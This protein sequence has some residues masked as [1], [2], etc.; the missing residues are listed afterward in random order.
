[1]KQTALFSIIKTD[2][3]SRITRFVI[4]PRTT[5]YPISRSSLHRLEITTDRQLINQEDSATFFRKVPS[6]IGQ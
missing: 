5:R 2:I 4:S 3:S 6:E 1:M